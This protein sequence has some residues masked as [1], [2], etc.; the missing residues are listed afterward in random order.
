MLHDGMRCG[1]IPATEMNCTAIV[2]LVWAQHIAFRIFSQSDQSI[3][4]PSCRSQL[5][6][7][8]AHEKRQRPVALS[9]EGASHLAPCGHWQLSHPPLQTSPQCLFWPLVEK[10]QSIE[11]PDMFGGT[12]EVGHDCLSH[13]RLHISPLIPPPLILSG[14]SPAT[15]PPAGLP[16]CKA[17]NE[18]SAMGSF[19]VATCNIL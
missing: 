19:G 11:T 5:L 7:T 2:P 1:G 4:A 10:Q 12:G 18:K 17:Y 6:A 14:L 15:Q 3:A 9:Y 8:T 13:E 16:L